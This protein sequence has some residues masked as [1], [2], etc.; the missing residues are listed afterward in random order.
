MGCGEYL[1]KTIFFIKINIGIMIKKSAL[2][3]SQLIKYLKDHN[4][5]ID[6]L[7]CKEC[8]KLII[9][10]NSYITL[11][12]RGKSKGKLNSYGMTFL[13]ERI[14]DGQIYHLCRCKNCVSKK[15]PE[16]VKKSNPFSCKFSK[17]VQYAFDVPDDIFNAYVH[18]RQ[19]LTKEKM[20][21]KYGEED[22][23]KRWKSYCNKQSITNTFE[24][25]HKKYGMTEDEFKEFN[26]SRACTLK[27]FIQRHGEEEGKKKWD[28]YC[29]RQ[30]YTTSLDYFIKEY[31][32][33][34]GYKKYHDFN[35]SRSNFKQTSNIANQFC[36]ELY[37]NKIFANHEIYFANKNFEYDVCGYRLDFYDKTLNI[38]IEFYGD[39]WHANPQKYKETD[40]IHVLDIN[41]L[42][43]DIWDK[44]KKRIEFIQSQLKCSII[45]VWE[46]AYKLYLHKTIQ[47]VINIINNLKEN[48]NEI[49]EVNI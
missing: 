46:S 47:D 8:G 2:N 26:K 45:I 14:Y 7:Y 40:E 33:D 12:H 13:S 42:V 1:F 16:L 44:D 38:A 29:E 39:L 6:Q 17:V 20:I 24:Y 11:S 35:Y 43:K 41:S 49:I 9:Y 18:E 31:G 27:L 21:T 48:K 37:N 36:E 19:A 30:R 23:I 32:L 22:G 28:E 3:E 34:D 10:D 5:N 25:K 4:E 15:Y